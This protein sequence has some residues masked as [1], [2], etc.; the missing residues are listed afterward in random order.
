MTAPPDILETILIE[1]RTLKDVTH[2]NTRLEVVIK[3][4]EQYRKQVHGEFA[5]RDGLITEHNVEIE[6]MKKRVVSVEQRLRSIERD[7]A[8]I[9]AQLS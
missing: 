9:G 7:L 5:R 1:L 4:L 8:L 2:V 3:E 6:D